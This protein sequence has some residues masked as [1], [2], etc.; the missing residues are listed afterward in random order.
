MS[1]E[2]KPIETAPEGEVLLTKIHDWHG[3]RNKVKLVRQGR[4]W[5]VPDRSMYVYYAPTHWKRQ[6]EHTP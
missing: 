4:L 3:C 6:Q 2:W 1:E 5:F